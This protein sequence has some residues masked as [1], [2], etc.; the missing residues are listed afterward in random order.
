MGAAWAEKRKI[1]LELERRGEIVTRN[2]DENWLPNF[3]RVWQSGSRK[4]S[5]KEFEMEK[6]KLPKVESPEM[7]V[8]IQPYISK[9]MVR[10]T[11]L[12]TLL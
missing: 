8:Q 3:G 12:Y 9:R 5:R 2:C 10:S 1:E 7:S 6:Q 11:P 4:E